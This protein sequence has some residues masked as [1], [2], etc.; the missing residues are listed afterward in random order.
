[1]KSVFLNYVNKIHSQIDKGTYFLFE[2]AAD[3]RGSFNQEVGSVTIYPSFSKYASLPVL[4]C[5]YN[6]C[7]TV[8]SIAL[9]FTLSNRHSFL[10]CARV[11]QK[12][13]NHRAEYLVLSSITQT[14]SRVPSDRIL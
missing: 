13:G 14:V 3:V 6:F 11:L 12:Y 4:Y 10:L 1:M 5:D 9:Y 7:S 2:I 8:Y